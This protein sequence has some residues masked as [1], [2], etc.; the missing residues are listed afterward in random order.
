MLLVACQEEAPEA[1]VAPEPTVAAAVTPAEE[2]FPEALEAAETAEPTVPPTA[3]P[4]EETASAGALPRVEPL[5]ECFVEM[6]E[7]AD[8]ECLRVEMPEFHNGDNGRSIK[9]SIVAS[10]IADPTIE[11]D[12]SC[13]AEAL[14]LPFALPAE[15]QGILPWRKESVGNLRF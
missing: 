1:T 9:E 15:Q 3:V 14:P 11:P 13:I 8:Y 5:E 2:A 6:P 7:G 12:G 10:F 4:T